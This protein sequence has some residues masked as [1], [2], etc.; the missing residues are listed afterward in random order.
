MFEEFK[1]NP[2]KYLKSLAMDFVVVLVAIS[3][4][5]YQM[6]TLEK[7]DTNPLVLIAKAIMGIICGIIIK[8]ALGEN[9]FS[10][11]YRSEVWGKEETLYNEACNTAEKYTERVDNF[12]LFLEKEKNDY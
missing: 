10:K 6:V 7:T 3:Y 9:G 11:G 5:F 8:Q 12:Y 2:I 1:E 4:I